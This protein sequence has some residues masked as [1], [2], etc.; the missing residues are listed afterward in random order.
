MTLTHLFSPLRVG[1]VE[2]RN[3]IFS[4]GHQTVL[5]DDGAPNDALIAYQEARARGGA[6][7]IVVSMG[8]ERNAG[9]EEALAGYTGEVHPVGDCL[10][11]RT[12]EEAVVEALEVA[13]AI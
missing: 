5:V 12:V 3:H 4:T 11:P 1:S 10:S 2:I 8:H 6:W 9:L 7:L 13:T